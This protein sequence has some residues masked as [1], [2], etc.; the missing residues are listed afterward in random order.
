MMT[1]STKKGEKV[2]QEL[3]SEYDDILSIKDVMDMLHIGKNTVYSLLRNNEIRNLKIGK[4]YII[5]KQS[6]INFIT[7]VTEN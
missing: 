6:V 3:F 4:R 2:N 1:R 7:A 5:P